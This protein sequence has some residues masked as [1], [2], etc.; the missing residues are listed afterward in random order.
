[1]IRNATWDDLAEKVAIY[2]AAIPGRLAT[3]DTETV[4]VDSRRSWFQDHDSG[5]HPLW[6][7]EDGPVI[8]WLSLNTFYA[9]PA[10]DGTAEVS[11][12][13][14]PHRQREGLAKELLSH[15]IDQAP[16]LGLR[17]F[18]GFVFSH[19]H[20]S[21][22]LFKNLGFEAWGR[23]PSVC[24]LDGVQRDVMILGRSVSPNT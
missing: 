10:W 1:M 24:V 23:L 21:L 22:T 12:Y 4:S 7:Y 18:L 17:I 11:V 8:G 16:S 14:T 6:V 2:N 20:P 9:R 15:A 19:N 5:Y 13:I 3:A